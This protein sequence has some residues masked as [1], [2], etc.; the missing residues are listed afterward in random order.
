[1]TLLEMIKKGEGVSA[2]LKEER[3][4]VGPKIMGDIEVAEDIIK[5]LK[6][7][8]AS[9]PSWGSLSANVMKK[10]DSALVKNNF[11]DVLT[12]AQTLDIL[13]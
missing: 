11:N 10:M 13:T 1:M 2:T 8:E 7:I 9:Q 6:D 12:L 4:K 5:D 3:Y